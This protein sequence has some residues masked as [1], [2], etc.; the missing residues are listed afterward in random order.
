MKTEKKKVSAARISG[1]ISTQE[2][3]LRQAEHFTLFDNTFMSVALQDKAA[4]QYVLRILTGIRDLAV[5]E[6]RSQYRLS[7]QVSHDAILDVLAE[8]SQGRLYNM[9][10]Q[11]TDTVDHARRTRFYAAMID[12]AYLEKG[13]GYEHLPEVYLIYISKTD[14]WH[15]GHTT[16]PVQKHFCNTKIEYQDGQHILYVNAAIDDGSEKARLMQ[17][18]KT[19]DPNDETH[20]D[21]SKHVRR[22]KEQGGREKMRSVSE[23][24]FHDGMLES[25]LYSVQALMENL[26]YTLDE[27]MRIL[28]VPDE[29]QPVIRKVQ[30]QIEAEK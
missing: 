14:L 10:I 23:E 29:D 20:G 15:A 21:L 24:I 3:R 8:D 17:Y 2:Q 5:R 13:T 22:L 26:H 27:A 25:E 1:R 9:E 18:F 11:R 6:V 16:Y 19:T 30:L 12:S 28:K 4:C 7:M